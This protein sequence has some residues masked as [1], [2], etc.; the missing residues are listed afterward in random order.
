[1]RFI[2]NYSRIKN[3]LFIYKKQ[4]LISYK[5]YDRVTGNL[6]KYCSQSNTELILKYRQAFTVNVFDVFLL[7]INVLLQYEI[8]VILTGGPSY[9]TLFL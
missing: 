2:S 1:M 5:L 7:L 8:D 9:R 4:Y 6:E 3:K